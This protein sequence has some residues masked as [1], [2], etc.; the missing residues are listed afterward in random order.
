MPELKHRVFESNG[1]KYKIGDNPWYGKGD[2]DAKYLV[3]IFRPEIRAWESTGVTCDTKKEAIE[4][5][6]D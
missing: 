1:T 3:Y 4:A 6:E 2:T 5:F